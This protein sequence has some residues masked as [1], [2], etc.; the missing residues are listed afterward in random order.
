MPAEV[1]EMDNVRLDLWLWSARFFKTRQLSAKAV[2]GGKV[3]LND[4]RAKPAKTVNIGDRID[5][6]RGPYR[7]RIVVQALNKKRGSA[8]E[9]AV[10]YRETED[11]IAEREKLAQQLRLQS[12]A[13][14]YDPGKPS[15]R[16]RRA[17][18]KLRQH[19]NSSTEP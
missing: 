4:E 8:T 15:K 9:A 3:R 16:D 17:M 18:R 6:K 7:T 5:I 12:Q 10:L 13:V 14:R 19:A 11:S 2:T 1:F